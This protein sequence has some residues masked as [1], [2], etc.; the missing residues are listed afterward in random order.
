MRPHLTGA[1]SFSL[2]QLADHDSTVRDISYAAHDA[3]LNRRHDDIE[4]W[5]D[6]PLQQLRDV[7]LAEQ[8][9]EWGVYRITPAGRMVSKG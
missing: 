4:A 7:G 5:A 1:G 2:R 6:L 8:T 3:G 9:A